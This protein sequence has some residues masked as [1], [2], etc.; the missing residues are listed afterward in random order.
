M[1]GTGT[2]GSSG[3]NGAASSAQLVHPQ[4]LAADSA[5]VLYISDYGTQTVRKVSNGVITTVAG[6]GIQGFSGDNGPASGAHLSNPGGIAVDA[7][8]ALYVADVANSRIRKVSN[9]VITTVAGTGALGFSGDNGPAPR[10]QLNL[11]QGVAADAAGNLYIADTGNN[12]IRKVSSGVI[13]SVVGNGARGFSGDGGPA[14]SGQL[15]QPVDVAVDSAGN[16]YIADIGNSHVRKVSNGTITTVAGNATSGISG[17]N[18]PASTVQLSFP[19]GVAVDPAGNLYIADVQAY[20]VRRVTDGV[21]TTVAGNGTPGFSGDNGAA[22]SAQ[23]SPSGVTLDAAGNLYVIDCGNNRIRKISNGIITTVAGNGTR[24][25]SGDNGAAI[26]AQLSITYA[27]A[28]IAADPVGNI[29]VPDFGNNRVRKISNGVI[30]TVAGTGTQGFSGDNGPATSARLFNPKGV[31]VDAVGNLY[32]ADSGNNRIRKV[33]NG[34]ITTVAGTGTEGF[35]GDNGPATAA[36]LSGPA[37][38]AVDPSGHVFVADIF[39]SRVRVL[40][41][42]GSSCV[43]SF[44]ST[45]LQAP[46]AG[47][48]LTFSIL[49]TA[50]CP[51][52]ISGLPGWITV[53]GAS[54]GTGSA[55]I[56]ILASP[57]NGTARTGTILIGGV[58]LQV[59]QPDVT[60]L[61]SI[62]S[63]GVVNAASSAAGS[64]VAP[65]SIATVYGDFLSTPLATASGPLLPDSLGG[66]SIQFGSGITA[67]LFAVSSSQVNFQVPWELAGQSKAFIT[68]TINGQ[69]S[70]AQAL[71]LAPSAPGIFTI[72]AAGTGQGAVLDTLFRLVDVSN[73]AIAGNSVIQIYCTGVGAVSNQPPSG[74][75]APSDVLAPTTTTPA[76]TI[77][78]AQATVL[79]SGLAPGSVGEYQINVLVPPGSSKGNAVPLVVRIG[80]VI[81]NTAT[82]AV[83]QPIGSATSSPLAERNRKTRKKRQAR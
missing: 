32:I 75:P 26:S 70:A 48:T 43:Y 61:P 51:W 78:G 38:V 53:S 2:P 83:Q 6:N 42:T 40:T 80:D 21:I 30:T 18:N 74:S 73:P 24:G 19:T 64:P 10:A 12:R 37:A 57:N 31:A 52:T 63:G 16:L 46:A 27:V 22:T 23:L 13:T 81:S 28:G 56:A 17:D 47:G 68:V 54:S 69:T 76:V 20:R 65:G 49:T 36:Q 25:F 77:G 45:S 34:V 44:S 67:P 1:A 8:G 71:N 62:N 9:G 35:S 58:S 15:S 4:F 39:N 72:N 79:F 3:D 7:A 33:S 82:I 5:N 11:A 29:Y 50:L 55:M 60:S 59:L 66:L 41:P 14:T